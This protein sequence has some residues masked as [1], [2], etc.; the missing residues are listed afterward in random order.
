MVIIPF[1][2][3]LVNRGVIMMLQTENRTVQLTRLNTVKKFRN[4]AVAREFL[5]SDSERFHRDA[6]RTAAVLSLSAG[7]DAVTAENL[8]SL[9]YGDLLTI[10]NPGERSKIGMTLAS[11]AVG[12]TLEV[13][14]ALKSTEG[15]E[16]FSNFDIGYTAEHSGF[17][18]AADFAEE[19]LG[20]YV[21]T[22]AIGTEPRFF[23]TGYSR[24]GAVANIL[25]KRLCDRCGT[26]G[27]ICY[28]FGAPAVTISR[29]Q[30]R[31]NSIFNLVRSED[32]F[33]RIPLQ[34]WGYRRYG[35][36]ISLSD[37]GDISA[38]FCELSGEEYIGFTRQ[39]A[40][41]SFLC[42]VA[43]LAPNVHAYYE[44]RRKVDGRRMSLYEF[45]N[46]VAGMLSH[47]PDE[48]IA[49]VFMGAMVSEY[50]DLMSFL[51]SGADLA[52]LLSSAQGVPRCS[53]ADSHSAVA[54]QA[55]LELFL[56]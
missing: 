19:K 37:V 43:G 44:R 26:D 47:Q 14:A 31:Y 36:D 40:V 15:S 34:S 56:G 54:Y 38:K 55:A 25:S 30:A 7:D 32:F 35:R 5:P 52:E 41:D 53:V 17:A 23:V 45:M 29:R 12:N 13:I 28:T 10:K 8:R 24:G 21:F 46:A 1:F 50:A 42:A 20:D 49:D 22:R 39:K 3:C 48:E 4:A 18:R 51:S 16:W 9:G 6:A 27:V 2:S 11:R 33:T